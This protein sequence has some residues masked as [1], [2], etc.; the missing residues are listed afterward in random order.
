MKE[1]AKTIHEQPYL[2][3]NE[4]QVMK[5]IVQRIPAM[6]PMINKIVFYGSKAR[7]DFI[8]ESDIDILFITDYALP[9]SLKFEIYDAIYELEVEYDVVISVVFVSKEVFGVKT[10]PFI[11]QVHREGIT[12]W[13]RG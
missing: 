3:Y 9:R 2:N 11:R 7:G 10:T 1:I 13:S 6:Y 8:E 4:Q 12:L 5:D